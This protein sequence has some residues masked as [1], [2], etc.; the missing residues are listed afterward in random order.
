MIPPIPAIMYKN[1][2]NMVIKVNKWT[3]FTV[4]I[5]CTY[6][7]VCMCICTYLYVYV[8][9]C[10]VIVCWS[11]KHAIEC[12]FLLYCVWYDTCGLWITE[13]KQHWNI[14]LHSKKKYF[15]LHLCASLSQDTET[16]LKL[17]ALNGSY[18]LPPS[19]SHECHLSSV[20]VYSWAVVVYHVS[21]RVTFEIV[22][23]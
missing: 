12:L 4:N 13:L 22:L 11:L 2:Q 19:D 16:N 10:D 23:F 14:R 20:N 6:V 8:C 7:C 1:Y 17:F 9:T 15:T 18:F 5:I 21:K 3:L